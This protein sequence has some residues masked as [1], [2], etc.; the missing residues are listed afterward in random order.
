MSKN[1]KVRNMRNEYRYEF[2]WN[3]IVILCV[4]LISEILFPMSGPI[5]GRTMAVLYFIDGCVTLLFMY[6]LEKYT[7]TISG[8][9]EETVINVLS[10]IYTFLVMCFINLIFFTAKEILH[11]F[12][13]AKNRVDNRITYTAL[14]S[15]VNV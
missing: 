4:M 15:I 13:N 10:N 11:L 5:G 8:M 2:F 6:W 9:Y 3:F 7:V 1:I 14:S 12:T